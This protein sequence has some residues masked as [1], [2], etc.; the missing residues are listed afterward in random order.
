MRY[1]D[2]EDHSRVVGHPCPLTV[3]SSGISLA[4]QPIPA[5]GKVRGTGC[6]LKSNLTRLAKV[7]GAVLQGVLD[8]LLVTAAG[9]ELQNKHT[10]ATYGH[11]HHFV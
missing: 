4:S 7:M 11:Y 10:T 3:V 8:L 6:I 1:S 9:R 2:P 5:S